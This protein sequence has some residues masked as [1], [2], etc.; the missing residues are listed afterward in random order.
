[1]IGASVGAFI[2]LCMI[3]V[4]QHSL[5]RI[6]KFGF[7]Y[8]LGYFYIATL[9]YIAGYAT[10]KEPK[11]RVITVFITTIFITIGIAFF[12]HK[13]TRKLERVDS[14]RNTEWKELMKHAMGWVGT[15]LV[16]TFLIALVNP[17]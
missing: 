3:V 9:S 6:R 14:P 16:F 13:M 8:I 5:Q 1:M 4:H 10:Y 12:G 7:N 11:D 15:V 2:F 17:Y